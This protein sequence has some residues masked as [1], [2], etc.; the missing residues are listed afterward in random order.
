MKILHICAGLPAKG[1]GIS[2][3]LPCLA[4]YQ[5]KQG[6]RVVIATLKGNLSEASQSAQCEGVEIIQFSKS[7]PR[8]LFFSWRMLL[9]LGSHIKNV[10]VVH[11]H[12]NWTFPVWWGCFLAKRNHKLLVMSP[13]GCLD[14]VRLKHSAWKKRL[15]GW[16]DRWCFRQASMIHAT[17][18]ME[19]EWVLA[20]C[21]G[22]V[23]SKIRVVSNGIHVPSC[24]SAKQTRHLDGVKKVLC[25]G[26]LHPLKGLDLLLQ[27][28]KKIETQN[29]LH[30]WELHIVG[31]DEQGT[32]V[33]LQ[34]ET[35]CMIKERI[36][37]A[38]NVQ[39]GEK[40]KLL[41]EVD[42]VV[43]PTRSENFGIVVGEALGCGVPVVVTK[44]APWKKIEENGCGY[45]VDV[46]VDG[47][48]DGLARMMRLTDEQRWEMGAK[49]KAW[50]QQEFDWEK[51]AKAINACYGDYKNK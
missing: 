35:A 37:F 45:W 43:L 6:T 28:W 19:R 30:H 20:F 11:I 46:S 14:S 10:D 33:N 3:S 42:I 26:R 22:R 23:E 13:R 8:F 38:E 12:S 48:A 47:I 9:K 32:L 1:G 7:F 51:I 25:L 50:T 41:S 31:P 5:H 29:D 39:G 44:G 34:D 40:W 2:E 4:K 17:S 49:G 24:I 27:A 36:H 15:V 18:W 21:G 16:M